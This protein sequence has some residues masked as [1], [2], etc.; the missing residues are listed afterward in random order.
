MTAKVIGI[1]VI[2]LG[3]LALTY[4]GFRYAYPDN[5]ANI[6]PVHVNVER[7][8][9]VFVPPLVGALAIA[10]GIGLLL[11]NRRRRA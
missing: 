10:G 1:V 4:G 2:L 11:V 3:V 8:G 6:G 9:T 5:V 7:H